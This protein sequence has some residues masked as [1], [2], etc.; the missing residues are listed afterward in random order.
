MNIVIGSA[1]DL[2]RSAVI[3]AVYRIGKSKPFG[4]S[5]PIEIQS[6][7]VASGVPNQPFGHAE[8]FCGAMNRAAESMARHAAPE[9]YVVAIENG[10]APRGPDVPRGPN[11]SFVDLA[12]V[13]V[14]GP[15]GHITVRSSRQV[16]VP[17]EL[18]SQSRASGWVQTCGQL[19]AERTP[20]CD[21]DD[22]HLV[23]S[24]GILSRRDLLVNTVDQALCAA[25]QATLF[26]EMSR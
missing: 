25:F 15:H 4:W 6:C 23:W 7:A 8:I 2:K 16:S 14:L 12:Y 26:V 10:V 18:V 17:A 20:D 1:S 5:H 19:E 13:V 22:P 11:V 9:D 24:S 21:H 3:E